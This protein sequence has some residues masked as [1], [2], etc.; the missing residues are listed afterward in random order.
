LGTL[1]FVEGMAENQP[2]RERSDLGR[3]EQ[4]PTIRHVSGTY[5]YEQEND[6][7]KVQAHLRHKKVTTTQIYARMS[8]ARRRSSVS[9]IIDYVDNNKN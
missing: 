3:E 9:S 1:S 2:K 6:I 7:Y 5:L 4:V 8:I